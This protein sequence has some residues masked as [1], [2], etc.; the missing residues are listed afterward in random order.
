MF[1][2][3]LEC[4]RASDYCIMTLTEAFKEFIQ[5]SGLR[6]SLVKISLMCFSDFEGVLGRDPF[7][8]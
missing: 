4:S 1:Q 5:A 3:I 7:L 2:N 8:F 6:L